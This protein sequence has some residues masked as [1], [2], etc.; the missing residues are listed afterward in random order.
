MK[1]KGINRYSKQCKKDIRNTDNYC[2]MHLYFE[3]FSSEDIQKIIDGKMNCCKGCGKWHNEDSNRC[4]AC[5]VVHKKYRN[6]DLEYC[7]GLDRHGDNCRN[8]SYFA[9]ANVCFLVLLNLI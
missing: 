8:Y 3:N 1:C 7:H 9:L 2:L 5:S 6:N 4:R